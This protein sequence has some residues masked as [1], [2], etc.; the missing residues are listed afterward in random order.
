LFAYRTTPH[1]VTRETPVKLMFNRNV[2]TLL[3]LI[4][5]MFKKKQIEEQQEHYKETH[6]I[7]FDEEDLVVWLVTIKR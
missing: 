5:P 1:C 7:V 2:R 6:D 3:D 4:K